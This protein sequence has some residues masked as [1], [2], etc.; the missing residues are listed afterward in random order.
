MR[1]IKWGKLADVLKARGVHIDSRGSEAKLTM[2]VPG[3]TR[4]YVLQHKC[5][6]SRS[7]DVWVVHLKKIMSK[8][9]IS[10]DD[11]RK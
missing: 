4:M 5:C 10:E 8:F 7:S 1:T 2:S 6:A 3:G 9:G 11:L